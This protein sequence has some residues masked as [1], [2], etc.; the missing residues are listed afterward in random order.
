MLVQHFKS[1]ISISDINMTR[2][3]EIYYPT[4]ELNGEYGFRLIWEL[5]VLRLDPKNNAYGFGL[6]G[7][8][9]GVVWRNAAGEMVS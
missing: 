8:G 5:F 2:R 9:F 7:F 4:I 1:T 3:A 6:L